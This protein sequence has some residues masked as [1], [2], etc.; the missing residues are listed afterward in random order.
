MKTDIFSKTENS[1]KKKDRKSSGSLRSRLTVTFVVF[2][3]LLMVIVWGLQTGFL[4]EFY[5]LSME[6]RIEE[7]IRQIGR[8]YS[9]PE[10][11]DVVTFSSTIGQMSKESDMY[12]CARAIDGS[13]SFNSNDEKSFGRMLMGGDYL[14]DQAIH[15]LMNSDS[16]SISYFVKGGGSGSRESANILVNAS[17]VY[18][19]YRTGIF[20]VT[21]TPITPLGPAVTIL[22]SLLK[23]ITVIALLLGALVAFF[24]SKR[25]AKP[26]IELKDKARQL[27]AGNYD[28]SFDVTGYKEIEELAST[29][30]YT[31]SELA[32][33]DTL[34]KDLLANISHDLR[35]PLTMIK[36]YAELIR[37]ISGENKERRDEHLQVIVEETDRLSDLVGDILA[38]SKLQAGTE[39]MESKPVDIQLAA[40]SILNVYRVLEEQDGF[41][42]TF[43]TVPETVYV[44]GDERKLQ[45]VISN[46]ISNAVRYSGESKDISISFSLEGDRIR[47]SVED[48]GIGIAPEDKDV[49]WN[50][51]QKASK[52]GTR[53][54]GTSTGLGLSIAREIL[55]R[56]NALYGV[57]SQLGQGSCFWFSMQVSEKTIDS[58]MEL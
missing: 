6:H 58:D 44:T 56:H 5:Q 9:E 48:H 28:V 37:D 19:K 32:K 36:S 12:I 29:L 50:R 57:E 4:E 7:G 43:H 22:S 54:S 35:T 10:T 23:I 2:A 53:T 25:M 55:E 46:M 42:F 20:L 21:V 34:Q 40:E 51:Y 52:Q 31:A 45:Q 26:V 39:S 14:V 13:F 47:F 27:A 49:I 1:E 30:T 8:E 16:E 18:S 17:I 3:A 24:Y 41:E 33:A 15:G 11:L 38:L